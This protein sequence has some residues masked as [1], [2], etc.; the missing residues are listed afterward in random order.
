MT[1]RL[2]ELETFLAIIDGNGFASAARRLRRSGPS[3]TRALQALEARMGTRLLERT[4]R[5]VSPTEAGQRLA[6]EAREVLAH[7][8]AALSGQEDRAEGLLRVTAPV[9]FGG[10]H[11]APLLAGFLDRHPGIRAELTLS[12]RNLDMIEEAQDVALRIGAV[13][14]SSLEIRRVGEVRRVLVASPGYLAR[15]G[16]PRGPAELAR[17]ALIFTASRPMARE[18]RFRHK[19]R[20]VVHRF[21]PRLAV[22]HI[23][24]ALAVAAAG[25]GIATALSYQVLND[26]AAG[27]F[28]RLLPEYEP[29]AM[30]VQLVRP[31]GPHPPRRV[32]L[33]LEEAEAELMALPLIR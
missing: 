2:E 21:M 17:H 18:W 1:D 13:A 15:H 4:T 6:A 14:Q 28:V 5:R 26:I 10:R 7:Y 30:P 19:G 33:F 24:A 31:S 25:Q 20:D 27:R 3:V 32:A 9:I 29:P 22:T 12:D 8:R 23:E 11:V 16:M